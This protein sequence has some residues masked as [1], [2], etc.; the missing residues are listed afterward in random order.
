VP[1]YFFNVEGDGSPPDKE[2]TVLSSPEAA[3]SAAV[4]ATGEMLRDADGGFW[5]GPDW[6]MH[7][8]DEQGATVCTLT[9][10]GSTG[11]P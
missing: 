9:V 7:V 3:R 1:R 11:E 4:V 2:A 6:Q 5:S 8:T 10:R